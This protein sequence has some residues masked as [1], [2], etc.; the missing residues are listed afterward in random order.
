[1][2][3]TNPY[4][5]FY[6]NYTDNNLNYVDRQ[7]VY[8]LD[9]QVGDVN[10]DGISDIVYLVGEKGYNNFY[11]NIRVMIQDGSTNQWHVIP[12]YPDL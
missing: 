6:G 3:Y 11:E 5:N 2:Y 9:R 1:M 8:T 12:L 4:I 7:N 10:G